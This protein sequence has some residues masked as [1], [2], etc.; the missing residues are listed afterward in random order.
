MLSDI[1]IFHLQRSIAFHRNK[2]ADE[3]NGRDSTISSLQAEI[4]SLN[5]VIAKH[6]DQFMAVKEKLVT[7]L[8]EFEMRGKILDNERKKSAVVEAALESAENALQLA[9]Q[10]KDFVRRQLAEAE[11][12]IALSSQHRSRA[13]EQETALL[14]SRE[15]QRILTDMKTALDSQL[16]VSVREL[17]ANKFRAASLEMKTEAV[18]N[19]KGSLTEVIFEL[20]Q[21]LAKIQI[22]NAEEVSEG[23]REL[24]RAR[25]LVES[26][27]LLRIKS[28][29]DS[30]M[31][32]IK[33]LEDRRQI[34]E[35][36]YRQSQLPSINEREVK[37]TNELERLGQE[38]MRKEKERVLEAEKVIM[39]DLQLAKMQIQLDANVKH[40]LEM[41]ER[42]DAMRA[43]G[44]YARQQVL[45]AVGF[46]M[47]IITITGPDDGLQNEQPQ[48]GQQLKAHGYPV[49][50]KRPG[51]V[52]LLS[53]RAKAAIKDTS[54][55]HLSDS[56][57]LTKRPTP[58]ESGKNVVE[59]DPFDLAI[60]HG[61]TD[62]LCLPDLRSVLQALRDHMERVMTVTQ[63]SEDKS[64]T[65]DPIKKINMQNLKLDLEASENTIKFLESDVYG[66]RANEGG[67][68]RII[69][70]LE[71]EIKG[72]QIL[73]KKRERDREN[74]VLETESKMKIQQEIE[75]ASLHAQV[76][77]LKEQVAAL[78]SETYHRKGSIISPVESSASAQEILNNTVDQSGSAVVAFA[79]ERA[80]TAMPKEELYA[81]LVSS[82]F[83]L[84]YNLTRDP[85]TLPQTTD[86]LHAIR[87]TTG[88][89]GQLD[90]ASNT[91]NHP[92]FQRSIVT[93]N[94]ELECLAT[95]V[96][97]K[98]SLLSLRTDNS[99]GR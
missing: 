39:L 66:L 87:E 55:V 69:A 24:L 34:A 54:L 43:E 93:D 70:Q 75:R 80:H 57:T 71:S 83:P 84:D 5:S 31:Q 41:D 88:A 12:L 47:D 86:M 56:R 20:K 61:L 45:D 97:S 25:D 91:I 79:N 26:E 68:T 78:A 89:N 2:Q 52:L 22:S 65:I 36:K 1:E 77:S 13:Q 48:Q 72:Y 73:G 49:E 3:I 29:S 37:M 40:A 90:D 30:E 21:Q 35:E 7:A 10:E 62:A 51:P 4:R 94:V 32:R 98:P 6:Q 92:L 50:S 9:R 82:N 33:E 53:P 15:Q 17:E 46:V 59:C 16:A 11:G 67:F 63:L 14:H 27:R 96:S 42:Y 85:E 28:Q 95:K 18:I 74:A 99:D 23:R 58:D 44:R 19:E 38:L 60:L 64:L 76:D 81:D 8:T